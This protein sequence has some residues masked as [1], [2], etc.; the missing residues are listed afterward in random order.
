VIF[1][2][3]FIDRGPDQRGV[4]EIVRPMI[5]DG[6]EYSNRDSQSSV[7]QITKRFGRKNRPKKMRVRAPKSSHQ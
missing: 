6:S 2:G 7:K 4:L 3:D 5:D 1:L